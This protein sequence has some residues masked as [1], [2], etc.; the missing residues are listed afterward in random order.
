MLS[1]HSRLVNSGVFALNTETLARE[2]NGAK[3]LIVLGAPRGGTSALAGALAAMGIYMGRGASAPVFESL[4]LANAIERDERETVKRLVEEF[5]GEHP[6]WAFKRPGFTRFVNAFHHYFRNPVYLAIF[7]DPA[8]TANRSY[9]S[10]RLKINYLKKLRR[11]LSTYGSVLDFVESSGAPTLFISYEKLLQDPDST[12]GCIVRELSL[13]VSDE[14]LAAGARFVEPS[15]E[16]YLEVS[17]SDRI[18]GDWLAFDR[19]RIAGWARYVNKTMKIP[20]RVTLYEG[21]RALATVSADLPAIPGVDETSPDRPC[22]FLFD[23]TALQVNDWKALRVRVDGEIRDFTA[24]P[25]GAGTRQTGFWERFT[26]SRS[27]DD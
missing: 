8:A 3:T 15:P 19:A 11:V 27:H 26:S 17:R 20:P 14:L 23:L 13:S 2:K 10:G 25:F 7:R 18:E 12:L 16:L 4:A 9:I 24:P 22:G 6:V 1:E 21:E 5:N